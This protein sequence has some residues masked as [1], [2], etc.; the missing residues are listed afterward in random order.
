[1]CSQC[2]IKYA[3]LLQWKFTSGYSR[4]NWCSHFLCSGF[5]MEKMSG[6]DIKWGIQLADKI[7]N[8]VDN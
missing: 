7:H 5:V 4:I 6:V 3:I 1:M 2:Y 8:L